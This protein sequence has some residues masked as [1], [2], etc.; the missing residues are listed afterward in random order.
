MTNQTPLKV[1]ITGV[2]GLIGNLVYRHL[3]QCGDRYDLYG[4]G[5]RI[6]SSRRAAEENIVRLPD[7]HFVIADLAD[8]EA[9]A[10]AIDGMDAVLHIGAVPDPSASFEDVLSSNIVGTYN[11][12]EACRKAGVRRL[13]YASSI[14]AT[15]GY[16][17]HQEPY[18]AIWEGRLEDIPEIIPLIKHTDLPRPT[19][20]YS[21][22][23]VWAEGFCRTYADAHNISTVCLRIGYVN[24]ED[25]CNH[26]RLNAVWCSNRDIVNVVELAL[27]ATVEP[28]F[29]ICYGVSDNKHRWVD[30]EHSRE[31]LGFVPQD[32]A[33]SST[34]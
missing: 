23:K 4:S 30:L 8:A 15:W 3:S 26:P 20:P 19:E 12:L 2:Y 17:L 32:S 13:V 28:R 18:R 11:V 33:E 6:A 1:H 16:Y 25:Y 7:D 21:A 27:E 34:P 22:S 10:N 24:K 5:R 29:D 14:M 9:V 31:R